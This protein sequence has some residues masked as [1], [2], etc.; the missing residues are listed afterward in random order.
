MHYLSIAALFLSFL[1]SHFDFDSDSDP[2]LCP[3]PTP[4]HPRPFVVQWQDQVIDSWIGCLEGDAAVAMRLFRGLDPLKEDGTTIWNVPPFAAH[5]PASQIVV[6][7]GAGWDGRM[8][9]AIGA[10]RL[11]SAR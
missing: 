6:G 11:P 8:F 2:L 10:R 4:T 7:F 5:L 1:G 3:D 9:R